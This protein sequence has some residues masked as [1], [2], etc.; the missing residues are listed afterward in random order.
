MTYDISDVTK[1]ML[2]KYGEVTTPL[3]PHQQRVVDRIRTQKGLVVAHGLGSGKTL[4]S[5]AAAEEQGGNVSVVTPASLK[6]NYKKEIDKHVVNP[7]AK[8]E[9]DSL[10]KA[11]R[12]DKSPT[13]DMLIVDEAHRLRE[14][15]TKSQKVIKDALSTKKLLL[16]GTSLYNRPHDLANLVNVAASDNVFPVDKAA[17]KKKYIADKEVKP[18]FI[19]RTFRGVKS[20]TVPELKNK[21]DLK[22]KLNKWVDYHESGGVDYPERKD[23]TINSQ[24]SRKQREIYDSMIKKA[25]PWVSYKVKHGL[26]PSKQ[27]S[28]DLNSFMSGAR[29]VSI[30]SGAHV[31]NIDPN[32]AANSSPKI[33]EAYKRLSESISKNTKHKALVYS[34]YIEAGINPYES[35]LKANKVAYG[36][37]TGSMKKGD[38]D[39]VVKE[40]NEGKLKV[41]LLSSAG[42]EGLDLKG[43]R[44]IQI[45]EPHWNKEK[46]EQVVA[47]GVRYKSHSDLP[48]NQQ[49]V[50]VE[51]YRSIMPE[52]N[53][54][55][56]FFGVKRKGGVDEYLEQMS[57]HKDVINQEVRDMLKGNG[58][59]KKASLNDYIKKFA[60]DRTIEIA[61][62]GGAI[63]AA[64]G[65]SYYSSKGKDYAK[66]AKL[67]FAQRGNIKVENATSAFIDWVG[68][69]Q[70][71]PRDKIKNTIGDARKSFYKAR[72]FGAGATILGAAALVSYAKNKS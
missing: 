25:P 6:S 36:K 72:R 23:I 41:L 24:M 1:Y 26:P 14:P 45:L 37:F 2:E 19:A 32:D 38:R 20:G 70:V 54:F 10:Q 21:K 66:K 7:K 4:T 62:A 65:A 49:K 31:K 33:K 59:N 67:L 3:K 52:P 27:E 22:S 17:F 40:Y 44:Q 13:G 43:T 12:N 35:M 68:S 9:V 64:S 69:S 11:V 18:S 47:R 34:N 56:R 53:R 48:K 39:R 60:K 8:Y 61:A 71:S 29:Q 50:D 46:I 51:H 57:K 58:I 28:K 15:S 55:K 5:I 16:T 42:G 30:S 63:A